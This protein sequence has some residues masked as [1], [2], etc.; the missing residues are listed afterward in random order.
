MVRYVSGGKIIPIKDGDPDQ[1]KNLSFTSVQKARNG[2]NV[3]VSIYLLIIER[4]L[5]FSHKTSS[6]WTRSWFFRY[7]CQTRSLFRFGD[8]NNEQTCTC[9]QITKWLLNFEK[10]WEL[11]EENVR[12]STKDNV[13]F[14]VAWKLTTLK[15]ITKRRKGNQKKNIVRCG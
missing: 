11:R 8:S 4:N 3:K 14:H 9:S 5:S 6:S 7:P 13:H 10:I 12:E 15:L 1:N 2:V